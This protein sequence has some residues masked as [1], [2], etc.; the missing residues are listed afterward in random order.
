MNNE[1]WVTVNEFPV[2]GLN[3][4]SSYH[5]LYYIEIQANMFRTNKLVL[6]WHLNPSDHA[7]LL[8]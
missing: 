4:Q 7:K 2:A 8:L 3:S 5:E 1:K 6:L